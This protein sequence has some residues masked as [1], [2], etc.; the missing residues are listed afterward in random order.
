M[1]PEC[2][3]KQQTAGYYL[4]FL[5][6]SN[7]MTSL[8]LAGGAA[9]TAAASSFPAPLADYD[10]QG[11]LARNSNWNDGGGGA[12]SDDEGGDEDGMSSSEEFQDH[13]EEQENSLLWFDYPHNAASNE[14]KENNSPKPNPVKLEKK[15]TA[16]SQASPVKKS[17]SR[18]KNEL[19]Q[20][21]P[22]LQTIHK[23]RQMLDDTDY[24]TRAPSSR[25]RK[26]TPLDKNRNIIP[27]EAT[28]IHQPT[29]TKKSNDSATEVTA[30]TSA[31]NTEQETL[32][33]S[34]SNFESQAEPASVEP[35]DRLW[36]SR[37]RSKYKKVQNRSRRVST[38][39]YLNSDDEA[40]DTD[41]GLGYVLPNVPVYFSD[42]EES[43]EADSDYVGVEDDVEEHQRQVSPPVVGTPSQ[44]IPQPPEVNSHAAGSNRPL[45]LGSQSTHPPP[46][47]Y[48]PPLHIPPNNMYPY[49]GSDPQTTQQGSLMR[50]YN[51]YLYGYPYT[52]Y[53]PPYGPYQPPQQQQQQ[54]YAYPNPYSLQWT[55]G[56]YDVPH[57][58][59]NYQQ[60][61]APANPLAQQSSTQTM[62]RRTDVR[63]SISSRT[64]TTPPKTSRGDST[65]MSSP[66]VKLP[67]APFALDRGVD[68]SG[69][70]YPGA[71]IPGP[72]LAEAGTKI[73]F[74]AIQKIGLMLVSVALACYAGVSPRSLP[75]T[76]YNLKFYE[77]FQLVS[78][79]F[80]SPA[81]K[82]L[83]VFD[84]R[85]NDVNDAVNT[86]FAS[87]SL[88]YP[89]AFMLQVVATTL[90]RLAVFA[91]F[92]PRI[93]SLAPK[94]PMLV[95]PWTLR[96]NRYRPKRITLLAADFCASCVASP[97][98]EEYVKLKTLQWTTNL[99]KNFRFVKETTSSK[100][101]KRSRRRWVAE[102]IPRKFGETDI[103]TANQYVTQMLAASIGFKL[104]DSGRRIL[105]YTKSTDANKS[106]YA[107]CRGL[108]PIHELCGTMTAIELARRDLLG[109]NVPL[110]RLLLPAA[111]FHGMANMR[112]KK[113][114]FRW[115][116]ST[117]WSE[118]Q[119]SPLHILDAST[120]PKLLSKGFA[121]LMWLVLLGRVLGY[122]IKN[123]YLVNRRAVKRTTRYAGNPAAFS[124]EMATAE[125][126]KKK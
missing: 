30:G 10:S 5:F 53:Q 25:K 114:V 117:P 42:G 2:R 120:L 22:P 86:F 78:L 57:H 98:I 59:H 29:S 58:P 72:S 105:M 66:G 19:E 62:P 65:R 70:T 73:S 43:D 35:D 38:P 76:E 45:Q 104:C 56:G 13:P 124:A 100:S 112:G 77:N 71:V 49:H 24:I 16:K 108:F 115:G 122:C 60:Q 121:K 61:G 68:L 79:A 26:M 99:R 84:A 33:S 8:A 85:E 1:T 74:D 126:L 90:I 51:P 103:I 80:I 94:V 82:F 46:Q 107:F 32:T 67:S 95:I 93:F 92:E 88:G 125:M 102:P 17:S 96:E 40:S 69:M 34:G 12:S 109:A 89:M 119:L 64:S 106:F 31:G 14:S 87:F 123:Y 18:P 47:G 81:I 6:V 116:S 111:V 97:I 101:S 23:L 83:S 55:P 7:Q 54:Q 113:P 9:A 48:T 21:S 27:I 36:T 110:W 52:P 4:V 20:D 118:M 11:H 44:T 15:E 28:L 3:R 63:A 37:D 91:W 75:L 50:P 41:D 39:I